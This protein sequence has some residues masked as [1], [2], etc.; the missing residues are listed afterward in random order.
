[1]RTKNGED[2]MK[3]IIMYCKDTELEFALLNLSTYKSE[4]K[5]MYVDGIEHSSMK[6][7]I[8]IYPIKTIEKTIKDFNEDDQIKII[9]T[10]SIM[11]EE[12]EESEKSLN[13]QNTVYINSDSKLKKIL[14]NNDT[15]D[16]CN[17]LNVEFSASVLFTDEIEADLK[18]Y[19]E[20]EDLF[21][22]K[23]NLSYFILYLIKSG[24]CKHKKKSILYAK[25][26]EN[27]KKKDIELPMYNFVYL[28]EYVPWLEL[29]DSAYGMN[30]NSTLN[31]LYFNYWYEK[32]LDMDIDLELKLKYSKIKTQ[33]DKI[34]SAYLQSA[35]YEK[36]QL[37]LKTKKQ[38]KFIQKITSEKSFINKGNKR[39]RK[40]N[41]HNKLL[42]STFKFNK[43]WLFT[44]LKIEKNNKV[45]LEY[46]DLKVKPKIKI[47]YYK[48]N[49]YIF[50]IILF[51]LSI[52]NIIANSEINTL[53]YLK[54][55]GKKK[56]LFEK[57]F[58]QIENI[59][60]IRTIFYTR[61]EIY[62]LRNGFDGRV[63]MQKK[64]RLYF[65]NKKNLKYSKK[66]FKNSERKKPQN[67]VLYEKNG[68]HM[69]ESAY[70]LFKELYKHDKVYFVLHKTSPK[71]EEAKAKYGEKIIEPSEKKYYDII[72]NTKY[73]IGTE[74]P[75]HIIGIRSYNKYVRTKIMNKSADFIFLQH[76]ITYSLS[77][78]GNARNL[79]KKN[80]PLNMQRIVVSSEKEA[81]HWKEYGG[82][83]DE[84]LYKTGM[85]TFDGKKINE[86]ADKL[87][88]FLTWRP[89]EEAI[90]KIE[91]TTYGQ[92]II[93]MIKKIQENELLE[94]KTQVILH[95]KF[96][97]KKVPEILKKYVTFESI[98][99]LMNHTDTLI[100]DYSSICYDAFYRGSKVIFWWN[101]NQENMEKYNNKI[102]LTENNIFG[103][104]VYSNDNIVEV[105]EKNY[106]NKQT[107]QN[108]LKYKEI[109]EFTDDQN[110]QRLLYCLKQDGII[111]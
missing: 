2:K 19:N 107:M 35:L 75:V 59:N 53:F 69:E 40:S 39:M 11:L 57:R 52:K 101:R 92:D 10:N 26:H 21:I 58:K 30:H 94:A 20:E 90:E 6:Y 23:R 78:E 68:E 81:D 103:D 27:Q 96:K 42:K 15:F 48:K 12:G 106:G 5:I 62:Y 86:D 70:R 80:S 29:N 98:D 66:A 46:G 72:F 111:K 83:T 79:F 18:S 95:P 89:W 61:D 104:Y 3:N 4:R 74:S 13:N 67:I 87:T 100:T 16:K 65:E 88:I 64:N 7:G 54:V 84:N 44:S 8:E 60:Y 105:I 47:P 108:I 25:T 97:D 28:G 63:I 38:E 36:K 51:T 73:F 56:Y 34:I 45:Q 31:I 93:A 109:N 77:L 82:F 49:G 110:M 91:D 99:E 22:E 14:K 85:V 43:L 50:Y 76:G 37:E 55:K 17:L 41:F 102:M 33:N 24:K 9:H 1:M 32:V 71:Y